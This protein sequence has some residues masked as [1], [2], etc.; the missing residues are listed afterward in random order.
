MEKKARLLKRTTVY[1]SEWVR[2]HK[3]RVEFPGGLTVEDHHC[4]DFPK[5]G[6]GVIVTDSQNRL[7]MIRSHRYIFDAVEWEIPAGSFEPEKEEVLAAAAREARE[8]SGYETEHHRLVYVYYPMTGMCRAVFHLVRCN[9]RG[10]GGSFDPNEVAGVSWK[11]R[12]A[13][14]EMLRTGQIRDGFTLTGI[15]L[16][17][18]GFDRPS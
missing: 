7:L 11:T 4:V 3:D 17:L 8:E 9:A 16:Y 12:E 18:T 5:Q 6:V 13:V 15:F 10:E 2:L 14:E 1:T